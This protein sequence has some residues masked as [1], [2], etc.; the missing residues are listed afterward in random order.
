MNLLP[1][2]IELGQI[3]I[4]SDN[5]N[6]VIVGVDEV[7]DTYVGSIFTPDYLM[8]QVVFITEAELRT[9]KYKYL[10]HLRD[11]KLEEPKESEDNSVLSSK[12]TTS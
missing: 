8:T 9:L 4:D 1:I 5:N 2:K 6:L 11:Y 3:Y 7:P 12:E 10:G